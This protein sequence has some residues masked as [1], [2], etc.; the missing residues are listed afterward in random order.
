MTCHRGQEPRK[1]D[2]LV[3]F[4]VLEEISLLPALFV[5][6][7]CAMLRVCF[8]EVGAQIADASVPVPLDKDLDW[9]L[10]LCGIC[11]LSPVCLMKSRDGLLES[12]AGIG[13]D[14]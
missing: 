3:S 2:T 4:A 10:F 11:G 5:G 1:D 7:F 14:E 13:C 12:M 6:D 9:I 8:A